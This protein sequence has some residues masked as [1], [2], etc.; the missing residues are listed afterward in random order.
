MRASKVNELYYAKDNTPS[1][2][3]FKQNYHFIDDQG[4]Q[5]MIATKNRQV[6]QNTRFKNTQPS[7]RR[8]D[9]KEPVI[10]NYDFVKLYVK[11]GDP[12]VRWFGYKDINQTLVLSD[13]HR[14]TQYAVIL[15]SHEK[16]NVKRRTGTIYVKGLSREVLLRLLN[17]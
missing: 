3:Q 13:K 11:L 15:K 5:Y 1:F 4:R 9:L 17:S 6:F 7:S 8:N 10:N 14:S 2:Y 16:H 12:S